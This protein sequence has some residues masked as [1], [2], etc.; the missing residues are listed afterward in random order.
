MKL[1]LITILFLLL[2]RCVF[3]QFEPGAKEISLSNSGTAYENDVFSLFNNAACLHYL[4]KK[5]AGVFY[6]PSPFGL[7]ELANAFIAYADSFAFGN[8]ALGAMNYG[9]EL[10]NERKFSAGYSDA[11][12]DGLSVGISLNLHW[13]K[14][15]N[16]GTDFTLYLNAGFS[17][18]ITDGIFWGFSLSNI[19]K[20][21][22]GKEKDQIPSEIKTGA[23]FKPVENFMISCAFDKETDAEESVSFG[24]NYDILRCISLRSGFS[25]R[26]SKFSGG[27]GIHYSIFNI[28]YAFVF[29][30]DL[31]ITHQ[32][33][34]IIRFE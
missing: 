19:N 14:I 18:M 29:H 22:F 9:Y 3:C 33:D 4:T 12:Y 17:L 31:G 20:A 16:Y 26:I 5:E 1:A 34:L 13:I 32:T 23:A 6:S 27:L 2:S 30:N 15:K 24:I 11:I 8:V 25:T 10:Y 28:N 21:T 7:K